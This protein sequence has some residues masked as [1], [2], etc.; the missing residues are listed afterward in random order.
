MSI[1]LELVACHFLNPCPVGLLLNLGLPGLPFIACRA[2]RR[3]QAAMVL[4]V[5]AVWL[6]RARLAAAGKVVAVRT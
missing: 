5:L 4:L 2:T 3:H 6:P 1:S